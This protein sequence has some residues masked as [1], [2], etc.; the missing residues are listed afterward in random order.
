MP[1]DRGDPFGPSRQRAIAGG[2]GDDTVVDFI[3]EGDA[4]D[5]VEAVHKAGDPTGV[6]VGLPA[7]GDASVMQPALDVVES[8]GAEELLQQ[9]VAVVGLGP[10]EVLEPALRQ[11]HDLGELRQVHAEQA[12]DQVTRLVETA[13]Q[14]SRLVVDDLLEQDRGLLR[15]GAAAALLRTLPGGGAGQVEASLAERDVEEDARSQARHGIVAA[16]P[17]GAAAVAGHLAVEGEAHC[18]EDARL[19]GPGGA[20][21]QEEPGVGERV[22]VDLDRVGE[23]AERGHRQRV[24]P[25]QP[26]TSDRSSSRSSQQASVASSSNADSASS[27][28]APRMAATKS[29]AI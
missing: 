11:Q 7:E 24:Q 13:G 27:A 21:Q 6:E 2:R 8:A 12:A 4:T 23:W 28:G 16:Q 10:E 20:A 3:G 5:L 25:H 15:R 17:L 22:E 26:A 9:L 14:V 18:V 19:A 1:T 29:R